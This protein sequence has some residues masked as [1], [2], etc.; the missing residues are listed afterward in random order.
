M[1][2]GVQKEINIPYT[3]AI[4]IYGYESSLQGS[5]VWLNHTHK[6]SVLPHH[7]YLQTPDKAY[8]GRMSK[9]AKDIK[10]NAL[11]RNMK[12]HARVT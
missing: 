11:V 4:L 12:E 6:V 1:I 2:K 5:R 3:Y 7:P 10:R 8:R 9:K